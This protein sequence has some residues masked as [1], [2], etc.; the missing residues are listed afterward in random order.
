MAEKRPLGPESDGPEQ[1]RDAPAPDLFRRVLRWVD[2]QTELITLTREFM[3]E[4]LF[5]GV[6]W[7]HVFGS[8]ALFLFISQVCT[9]ILLAVYYVP[10]PDGA[11]QS[12]SYINW[13]VPFGSLV[14]GLHHWGASAMLIIVFMH[15]LQVFFWGA[16]KRPRQILWVVGV[17]L[18]LVTL[19]LS[20]T[21]YLLPWDQ[22]A[23]WA[24]V[25]GTR[26]AGTV[27]LVGYYIT[28]LVRGEANIGALTLTRFFGLHVM[29]FP[30]LL[31]GLIIFHVSQ[32]RRKGITA[33]WRRVGD[34][35]AVPRTGLFYPDQVF[36]DAVVSL[37][38]LGGLF[39][40]AL[41]RPAPL[42]TIANP[43]STGY[44][45]RPEWYFLPNFE[46]LKH[47]PASWGQWGEF[48]G[49]IVIPAVAVLALLVLPYIDHNPERV[50]QRRPLVTTAAIVS[51][52][53]LL[54]LGAAGARSGPRPVTLSLKEEKG[55]KVFLDLRCQSCHSINGGGGMEGADL[56]LGGPRSPDLVIEKLR[57]PTYNN[58]RSVMPAVPSSVNDTDFSNLVAYVSVIDSR[59]HMPNEATE[60]APQKPASHYEGNWFANHKYEVRKDPSICGQCHKPTF[61]QS[62]HRNRLP[63]SHLNDWLKAHAGASRDRPEYCLVCHDQ[64]FCNTCHGKLQHDSTW[65]HRHQQV[66][67]TDRKDC[68]Q[69]HQEDY[70]TTCH[71][72]ATPVTH[73]EKGWLHHHDGK[74]A[75]CSA[76][77]TASFC[78]T[79]HEGARPLSHAGKDWVHSHQTAKTAECAVCH[80]E[81]FCSN[82]HHG[83]KPKSHDATWVTRHG[84]VAKAGMQKCETCH[85]S[86][87][88]LG[89]HG[90]V[91]MPHPGDWTLSHKDKASFAAGS[92]CYRCHD[93]G[94]FCSQCHGETPPQPA[95]K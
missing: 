49:A 7:P 25:V 54:Y 20:F 27:P 74:A 22:K 13:Q 93:Y 24:T 72:G 62:C 52:V 5:K 81:N 19:G 82:C 85:T 53:V 38:A 31:A 79:C 33:P 46:L 48:A 42:E 45:P 61:C 3:E 36:K 84:G 41:L 26:I 12:V 95:S 9:G 10:S 90:G 58:P 69:C 1:G 88:C 50:P 67:K 56:A 37:L 32:V 39:A 73:R 71:R 55:E 89:C 14:R 83:A 65:M 86:S 78:S 43:T 87:F 18:L 70:C 92:A 63:D 44:T 68:L 21:G 16:Y 8:A 59:F 29:I 47:F 64:S 2:E 11:W 35:E 30:A 15:M 60:I 77:H 23:Y 80:S 66:A 75:D 17:F 34:E 4:P 94:K 6:G 51:L 57:D 28:T 40:M 91:Q 76:C